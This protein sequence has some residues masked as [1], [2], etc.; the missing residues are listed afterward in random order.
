MRYFYAASTNSFYIAGISRDIPADADE[1]TH[2]KYMALIAAPGE[3]QPDANGRP[4][5]IMRQPTTDEIIASLTRAVQRHLDSAARA[6]GYDDIRTAVTYADEPAVSKF[7]HEGRAFRAWRSR[8]WS[9]CND[10]IAAAQSGQ[11]AMPSADDLIA[12][13]PALQLNGA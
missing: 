3:L 6:A 9:A 1:I 11:H 2:G 7:Q 5:K 4:V 12:E 10:V 13:L 8:V